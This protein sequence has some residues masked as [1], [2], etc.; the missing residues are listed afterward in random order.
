MHDAR[1]AEDARLLESG[2]HELLLA[3]YY[4]TIVARAFAGVRSLAADDVVQSVLERL[5]K[6][7]Q[8]G[9]RYGVPFRVV[10]HQVISWK[11][12]EHF[13]EVD[14]HAELS[15]LADEA[16]D[17]YA[18]WMQDH[19]LALLLRELPDRQREVAELRYL[20]GYEHDEIAKRLKIEPNAVYQALH[21]A[22]KKLEKV[23]A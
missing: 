18:T 17:A 10:V 5:W 6:E 19:D 8:A 16:Y 11:V 1:D 15:E 12:K 23:Y 4:D 22:H 3:G 9:K 20:H 2:E 13:G 21:N 14:H 7:L